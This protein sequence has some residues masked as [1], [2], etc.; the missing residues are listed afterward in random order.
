MSFGFGA[1]A[2]PPGTKS[3]RLQQG[4]TTGGMGFTGQFAQQQFEAAHVRFGS[5]ADIPLILSNVCFTPKSRHC[6]PCHIAASRVRSSRSLTGDSQRGR[7][8]VYSRIPFGYARTRKAHQA[9]FLIGRV[10]TDNPLFVPLLPTAFA[11]IDFCNSLK[12]HNHGPPK[13][14]IGT[15]SRDVRFVP[16]LLQKSVMTG[17]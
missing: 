5:K 13:A 2:I 4:F 7:L 15:H 12:N 1:Y 14:D 16:I 10:L 8:C 3:Q 6:P 9:G 11:S 17:S